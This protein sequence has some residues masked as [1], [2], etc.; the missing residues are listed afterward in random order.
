MPVSLPGGCGL[1]WDA[2]WP[3]GG[4]DASR[5][6]FPGAAAG[7][8]GGGRAT[9]LAL[10]LAELGLL[11]AAGW[12]PGARGTPLPA[13]ALLGGAFGCYALAAVRL[14]GS[15]LDGGE[16]GRCPGLRA[17]DLWLVGIA[18]RLALLP[19]LPHFTDD[20]Y[21][22]LWDGWV[23]IHGTN[24]YVH[25]PAAPELAGLRT[26]WHEAIN[27]P[28]VRTIY[29]PAAQVVFAG[30]A[31]IHPSVWL[32][33][34][35]WV[36]ADLGVAGVIGRLAERA[37]GDGRLPLLLYLWSPLLLLEVAWSGH[38]EPL[39]LLPMLAAVAAAGASGGAWLA[40]S[41][42]V[43]FAPAAA[44]P[45]IWRRRGVRAALAFAVPALLLVVPYAVGAGPRML[46]GLGEYASRWSFNPGPHRLL[47]ALAGGADAAR[48][49]GGAAV[50]SVAGWAA[51]RRWPLGRTLLWTIGA[52]LLV[53]PTLHPWYVLWVLP[54]AAL[55]GVRGWILLTG[56]ALL[57]Y[58]H[59]DHFL[60][61]GTWPQPAWLSALTWGPPL[62]LLILD[63][64]PARYSR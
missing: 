27:H 2:S 20:I 13:L 41:A 30:L 17:R 53:S 37:G 52:G 49:A 33:K 42:G 34:A 64:R 48:W 47:A 62:L 35:A 29:P 9:V 50:A 18:A 11:A 39:G 16:D 8:P 54:F 57:G 45:A 4:A 14:G 51:W 58:W 6:D 40:L 32:F 3:G 59:H 36:A 46:D 60:A 5:T 28:E 21:R 55:R 15:A 63:G 12:W 26:A 24:P 38:L 23:Q 22:Y 43:K 1:P 7:E 31:A 10:G 44:L 56:T 25:A 19:L 61:T